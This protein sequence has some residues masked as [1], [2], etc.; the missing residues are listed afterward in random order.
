MVNLKN[1]KNVKPL[2]LSELTKLEASM[3]FTGGILIGA[4]AGWVFLMFFIE[5][6]WYFKVLSSI[7]SLGIV[8][9]LLLTMNELMKARNNY[10]ETLAEME[11]INE[12][13]MKVINN[14][15][16]AINT[17]EQNGLLKES[18]K[19]EVKKEVTKK[20]GRPKKIQ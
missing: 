17:F 20:H 15:E 7:G 2:E 12:E 6:A 1:L 4:V 18:K 10:K 8:G 5:W 14:F 16:Q 19:E 13:S 3:A 9:S 11:K